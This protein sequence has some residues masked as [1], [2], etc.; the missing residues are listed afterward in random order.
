MKKEEINVRREDIRK[1]FIASV[2]VMA[3]YI[4][5]GAGFGI[6]LETKGLGLI[7]AVAMSVFIYAGSMQYVAIELITGGASL[8]TTALTTLM[9]NA[10]HLF[11]GISMVDKYK[12]AGKK[13]PY[14]IFALTDE[15]YS[16]VCSDDS[17]KDVNNKYLYY[18]TVSLLNQIYWITGT[19]IGSLS[20]RMINFSTEGIDF[21]LT[22]L[23]VTIFTEQWISE[24][25]H[26]PA[27]AG[28]ASSILCLVVF[29]KDNFL[30][31]AMC[32]IVAVLGFMRKMQGK[33]EC[34]GKELQ[35]E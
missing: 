33:A 27:I 21:A 30:I 25:N 32:C 19:V 6:V 22:A 26:G 11:Y 17:V 1:A 5:L 13:K 20:G 2:P 35:D 8:I 31:P 7:W 23:F 18:F 24:K 15:T 4:V 29:G 3:G 28:L 9:V 34:D 12:G 14:L 10:R 16:L